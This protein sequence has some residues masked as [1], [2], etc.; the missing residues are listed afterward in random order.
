[1]VP[2]FFSASRRFKHDEMGGFGISGQ[3]GHDR[4][5][6]DGIRTH[7]LSFTKAVPEKCK[8]LKDKGLTES[9][10]PGMSPGISEIQDD[11]HLQRLL[12]AWPRLTEAM[13]TQIVGL[14]EAG[15]K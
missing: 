4:T 9:R 5:A 12:A 14:A 8:G 11:P 7:N 1:M 2:F 15:V 10:N 13:R 6:D 3:T